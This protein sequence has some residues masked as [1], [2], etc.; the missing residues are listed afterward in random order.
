MSEAL[1]EPE[2]IAI[3]CMADHLV[4]Q[5]FLFILNRCW[6]DSRSFI[7]FYC[8]E[9]EIILTTLLNDDGVLFN[10]PNFV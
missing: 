5:I 4:E 2:V 3:L 10:S 8:F 6:L 9:C 1:S 7:N